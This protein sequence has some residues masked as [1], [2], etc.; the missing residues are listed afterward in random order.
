HHP[1]PHGIAL[2][3]ILGGIVGQ[4][5]RLKVTLPVDRSTLPQ[6]VYRED[7]F[8][9]RQV[10]DVDIS[11]CVTEYRAQ[12]LVDQQGKRWVA[13]FPQ[14]VAATVQYGSSVK[15]SIAAQSVPIHVHPK[16]TTHVHPK[17]TT[18]VHP[19]CTSADFL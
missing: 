17:C 16:C 3:S 12:V 5:F 10:F 18:H 4:N 9:S 1:Q 8:E 7:G 14:E 2:S 15:V 11:V 13:P 19:K 6:G